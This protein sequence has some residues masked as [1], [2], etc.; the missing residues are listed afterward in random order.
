[1]IFNLRDFRIY[2]IVYTFFVTFIKQK[3]KILT[4]ILL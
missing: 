2:L 1:M 3:Y 4:G